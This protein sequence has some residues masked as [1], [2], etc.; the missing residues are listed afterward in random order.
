MIRRLIAPLAL[1][2]KD[3]DSLIAAMDMLERGYNRSNPPV[4]KVELERAMLLIARELIRRRV[5]FWA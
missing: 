5:V 4:S 1:R 3:T 2:F